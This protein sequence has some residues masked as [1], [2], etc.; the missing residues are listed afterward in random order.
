MENI[1][2]GR[3]EATDEEVI[4]A[5]KAIG[6]DKFISKMPNGYYSDIGEGG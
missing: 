2:Y 3:L 4:K 1:R 6:A 5:A